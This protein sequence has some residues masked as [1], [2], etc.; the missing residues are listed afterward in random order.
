VQV[1]ED[2]A[3]A[4]LG[5]WEGKSFEEILSADEQMLHRVRNQEPIWRHAPFVEEL[6][7]FRARVH[8]VVERLL[9]AHS[10]RQRPRVL[11]RRGDQRLR[12]GAARRGARDVLRAREHVAQLHRR[13]G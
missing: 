2:L 7:P 12:R 10:R 13:R 9:A 5:E 6:G 11:P 1:E 8:A 3:E 4:H